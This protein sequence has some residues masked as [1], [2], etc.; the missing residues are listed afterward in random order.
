MHHRT[1]LTLAALTATILMASCVTN[2][3]ANRLSVSNKNTRSVWSRLVLNDGAGNSLVTCPVTMEGS[4]HSATIRKVLGA[5]GGYITRATAGRP[6][7]GGAVTVN[8]ASLPWHITYEGF[9]GTLPNIEAILILL[10]NV[11]YTVEVFGVRC[12]FGTPTDN[13]NLIAVRN[14]SGEVRIE[15]EPEGIQ[16]KLSGGFLCPGTGKYNQSSEFATLL[17]TA[18]RI[19]ITLI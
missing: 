18:T 11:N 2:T 4:F 9:R 5:L 6:C 16:T 10:I 13:L 15:D 8:Q 17:G 19:S 12:G 7:T 3:S 14:A 1:R